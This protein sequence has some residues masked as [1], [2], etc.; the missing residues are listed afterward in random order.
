MPKAPQEARAAQRRY[1]HVPCYGTA[2]TTRP[3]LTYDP[4]QRRVL[5]RWEC[6]GERRALLRNFS[7]NEKRSSL[8][9]AG[10][11]PVGPE[12]W[13]WPEQLGRRGGSSASWKDTPATSFCLCRHVDWRW[14]R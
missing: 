7:S 2:A 4:A 13:E 1:G 12:E 6:G 5:S 10:Q 8:S 3:L 14:R 11:G 9:V